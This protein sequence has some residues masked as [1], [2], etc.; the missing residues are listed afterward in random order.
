MVAFV[1]TAFVLE[2]SFNICRSAIVKCTRQCEGCHKVCDEGG[3]CGGGGYNGGGA[4]GG[5]NGGQEKNHC[6]QLL[7]N[8]NY[9]YHK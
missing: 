5:K 9:Q 3:G 4:S 1:V 6:K 2:N 8:H 7:H